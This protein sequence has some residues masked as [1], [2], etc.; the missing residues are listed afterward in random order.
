MSSRSVF[1][2]AMTAAVV[3]SG[4]T[5]RGGS[6]SSTT[7]SLTTTEPSAGKVAISA[8]DSVKAALLQEVKVG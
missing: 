7:L 3:S 6:T 4:L 1:S 5:A 2:V 8:P